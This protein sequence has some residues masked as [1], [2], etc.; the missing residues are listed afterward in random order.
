MSTLTF[1]IK[2]INRVNFPHIPEGYKKSM[3]IPV[4]NRT[5]ELDHLNVFSRSFFHPT[6]GF[7]RDYWVHELAAFNKLLH[8]FHLATSPSFGDKLV[9]CFTTREYEEFYIEIYQYQKWII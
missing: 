6:E 2:L 3:K 4:R 1:Q 7:A 8:P 5:S 9:G